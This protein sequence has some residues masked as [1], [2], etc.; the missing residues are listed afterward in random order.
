VVF[1]GVVVPVDLIPVGRVKCP[2]IETSGFLAAGR[3]GK[4]EGLVVGGRF[5]RRRL[6]EV[7]VVLA[8]R[9]VVE[10][11]VEEAQVMGSEVFCLLVAAG[12]EGNA[13]LLP[14]RPARVVED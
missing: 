9:E 11:E 14:E 8:G 5:W 2:A 10:D 13:S 7:V 4:A 3:E 12:R 1:R 6:V